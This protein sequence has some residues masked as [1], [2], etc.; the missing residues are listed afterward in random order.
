MTFKSI[1]SDVGNVFKKLITGPV[2]ELTNLAKTEE[3]VV[4]AT[5]PGIATP[6]NTTVSAAVTAETIF[7]AAGAQTGTGAQ[8]LAYVVSAVED[9]FNAWWKTSLGNTEPAAVDQGRRRVVGPVGADGSGHS[10]IL[11][12]HSQTK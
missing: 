12:S 1:L 4:D 10:M 3:P 7:A 9:D 8:K 5:F 6:Y 2:T 11:P